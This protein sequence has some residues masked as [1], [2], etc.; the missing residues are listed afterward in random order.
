MLRK[1][2]PNARMLAMLL[3]CGIAAACSS[4]KPVV[5]TRPADAAAIKANALGLSAAAVED[6][7]GHG[8]AQ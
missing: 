1:F 2:G 4:P 7:L 5:D 3:A 6:D 8:R